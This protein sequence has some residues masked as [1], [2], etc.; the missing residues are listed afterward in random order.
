MAGDDKYPVLDRDKLKIPIHMIL[1]Q[2]QK[3]FSEFFSAFLKSR[4][5]FEHVEKKDGTHRFCISKT[6]E[7]ENVVRWVSKKSCFRGPFAE[8]HGKLALTLLEYAQKT[9]SWFFLHFWN[10]DYILNILEKKMALID[11]VFPK[12]RNLKTWL[13]KC[14]TIP[15]SEDPLKSNM[16]NGPKHCWNMHHSTF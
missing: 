8:E 11:F 3:T 1:S 2:K 16:V 10:L 15:V 14:L 13:D 9:F 4:L 12:L 6:T 5:N 7:S